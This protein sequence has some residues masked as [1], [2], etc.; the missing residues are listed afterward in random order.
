MVD[1]S[2]FLFFVMVDNPVELSSG[3]DTTTSTGG[4]G[5]VF[6]TDWTG[7]ILLGQQLDLELLKL[8]L[9]E[10]VKRIEV[11]VLDVEINVGGRMGIGLIVLEGVTK[12][13]L[14]DVRA[15]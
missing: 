6:G 3:I 5:G 1:L 8:K 7:F 15:A 13:L 14:L 9:L 2:V 11:V 4:S 10:L 12:T